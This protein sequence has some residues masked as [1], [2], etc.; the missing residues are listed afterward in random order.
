MTLSLCVAYTG[1]GCNSVPPQ[2]RR[3][4]WGYQRRKVSNIFVYFS[5]LIHGQQ[6]VLVSKTGDPLLCDFG[7]SMILS[8]M[9]IISGVPTGVQ[10]GGRLV[11]LT[12]SLIHLLTALYA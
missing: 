4:S 10:D 7:L 8:E 1:C 5:V 6:N 2:A 11:Y 9:A 12:I 3:H